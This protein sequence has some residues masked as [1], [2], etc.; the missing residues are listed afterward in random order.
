MANYITLQRCKDALRSSYQGQDDTILS[1]DIIPAVC[2]FVDKYCNRSPGGLLVS[3][4]DQLYHGTGDAILVVRDVPIVSIQ[5]VAGISIP[6]ILIQNKNADM[7]VRS[8]ISVSSTGITLTYIQSAITTT[9]TFLFADYPTVDDITA[10]INAAGNNW[11]A[12]SQNNFGQWSSADLR[13]TQGAFGAKYTTYLYIHWWDYQAY[14]VNEVNG[15]IWSIAGFPRGMFNIRITYMAGYG[16]DGN[17]NIIQDDLQQA[18]AELCAATY[19]QRE[20]NPNLSNESLGGLS[21]TAILENKKLDG[22]S[23]VAQKTLNMYRRRIVS[24][25]STW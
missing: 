1:N 10:Q 5:R 23:A 4:Q 2:Q 8:T 7:S 14:R 22:L 3:Q 13:A 17:G 15:E 24:K 6:A 19:Y 20:S 21:Y 9:N 11:Y 12:K 18:I 16:T 25:F